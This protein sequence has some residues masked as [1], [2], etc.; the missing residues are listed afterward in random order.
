MRDVFG[1]DAGPAAPNPEQALK[2]LVELGLW[3]PGDPIPWAP[4]NAEPLPAVPTIA[5]PAPKQPWE[6]AA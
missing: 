1:H 2:V 3:K 5:R 6:V 4:R